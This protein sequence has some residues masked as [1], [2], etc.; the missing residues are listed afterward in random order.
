MKLN[1]DFEC[2]FKPDTSV[3]ESEAVKN[4]FRAVETEEMIFRKKNMQGSFTY[5]TTLKLLEHGK[6][7]GNVTRE[8][9]VLRQP[10][11]CHSETN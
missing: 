4:N 1:Q 5:K 2:H 11:V 6:G 3:Q 9:H 8:E 10:E 7:N